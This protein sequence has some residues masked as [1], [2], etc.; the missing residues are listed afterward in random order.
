[1]LA[2]RQCRTDVAVRNVVVRPGTA[3]YGAGLLPLPRG[4][5]EFVNI[6]CLPKVLR[7]K[8]STASGRCRQKIACDPYTTMLSRFAARV[9]PV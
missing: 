3:R 5:H 8:G 6:A 9:T 7:S 2:G 4:T 1:M